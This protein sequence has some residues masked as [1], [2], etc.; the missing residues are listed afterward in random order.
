M[1]SVIL[2]HATNKWILTPQREQVVK[3]KVDTTQIQ[4]SEP[5]NFIR[6]TYKKKKKNKTGMKI[7]LQEQKS[8]RQ[9]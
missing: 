1:E 5:M 8:L 2:L 7:Y 6:V 3:Q 9:L 4:L